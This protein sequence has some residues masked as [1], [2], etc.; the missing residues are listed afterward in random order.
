MPALFAPLDTL[1][2]WH[3]VA[4]NE[5][6]QIVRLV[7]GIAL[8]DA[9]DVVIHVALQPVRPCRSR[10]ANG[11]R[12]DSRQSAACPSMAKSSRLCLKVR[13]CFSHH[14]TSTS[15]TPCTMQRTGCGSL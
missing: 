1:P 3:G 6:H 13:L 4:A 7:A 14:R 9:H 15:C 12:Q 8:G 5:L 11:C 2:V 10:S